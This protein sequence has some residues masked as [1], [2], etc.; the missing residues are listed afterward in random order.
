M[1]TSLQ[2]AFPDDPLLEAAPRMFQHG[3]RHLPLVD[4]MRR[5][6]GMLSDRDIRE[7]VGNP[8]LALDEEQR[9]LGIISYIDLL[10][11]LGRQTG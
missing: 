3:S 7:A 10:W 4:G 8:L 11:V 2:A 6:V 1:T 5:V 9:L